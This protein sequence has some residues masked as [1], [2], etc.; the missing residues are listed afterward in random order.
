VSRCHFI[1]GEPNGVINVCEGFATAATVREDIGNA[2]VVAF[3]AGNLP[4]VAKELRGKFL[5]LQIVICADDD[6]ATPGNP[7]M[8][9][10]RAAA[11]AVGGF[12]AV[13][14]FGEHRPE[15]AADFNDLHKHAGPEAV[16]ACIERA[17]SFERT[18][19]AE[20]ETALDGDDGDAQ[21]PNGSGGQAPRSPFISKPSGLYWRSPDGDG[22]DV[23]LAGPFQ[24]LAETRD[25]DG[26][27]WGLLLQWEDRDS[28]TKIWAMPKALLAGDGIDVRRALLDRGLAIA[29]GTKPRNLLSNYLVSQRS[30]NRARA[31]ATTG[32]YGGAFVFPDGAIGK[33]NGEHCFFQTE[34]AFA[35]SYNVR[36]S[37][38]EWKENV[39]KFAIGNSR[40]AFAVSTSVASILIHECGVESGGFHLRGAS[41]I[42]KS[43]A[44]LVA[45]SLWGGGETLGFLTSWRATSNGLEG[46][47]VVHNDALLC[48]DEISQVSAKEAGDIA[49]MLANSCG[50]NRAA[51]NGSLRK[52]A[53]WRLLFLS[54]G[55]LSLADKIAEDFRG[56]RQTAGQEVRFVDIPADTGEHGLFENLHGLP[57]SQAF[58]DHLRK[59][60]RQYYGTAA[61]ALIET[62]A[63]E[64]SD[65][66]E[67]VKKAANSFVADHCPHGADFQVQRVAHRFGFV[68]AAGE[69]AIVKAI[70][71]WEAGEAAKAAKV[72]FDAWL[73]ARGGVEPAEIR[74]GICAIRDFVSA[75]GTSRFLAAWEPTP[76]N[77]H[78]DAIPEKII[79]LAGYRAKAGDGWDFYFTSGGWREACAGLDPKMIAKALAERELLEPQD[80]RHF[81]KSIRIP[82]VGRV[83]AYHVKSGILEAGQ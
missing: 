74:N 13:P 54:S 68:A 12:L 21:A 69:V 11:Q 81:A 41:S 61:R 20:P 43:T 47:A 1:L 75:H 4:S 30:D 3:N 78:G 19:G 55:E 15:R 46:V 45:G 8:K 14:D 83:R 70:L 80:E 23:F 65:I 64:L 57:S 38:Q 27:N 26:S 66:A 29:S 25:V 9:H 44:L 53:Q 50:K 31:V 28:R 35:H 79:N 77:S 6:A 49:Y 82:G 59:T 18:G 72:C 24:I 36:G 62:I 63:G 52:P 51:R 48:L 58:A 56:K 37:L 71:P 7:G 16:R 40:I 73:A 67:A 2:V 39:A 22:D 32:W 5:G 34:H 17:A 60:A 42:G 10:A 33:A 76:T